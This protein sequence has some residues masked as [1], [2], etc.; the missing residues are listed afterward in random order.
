LVVARAHPG[1]PTVTA[2]ESV[3]A[4]ER[5]ALRIMPGRL[6]S[7]GARVYGLRVT[8]P[9][10]RQ[11]PLYARSCFAPSGVF[12]LEVPLAVNDTAGKWSF[13]I[14]DLVAAETAFVSV[15]VRAGEDR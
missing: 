9:D 6:G 14:R 3:S 5:L 13:A 7:S 1:K 8:G 12:N 11:R 2:P 10:G 15:K 4:G